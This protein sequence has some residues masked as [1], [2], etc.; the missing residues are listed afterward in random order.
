MALTSGQAFMCALLNSGTIKCWGRNNHG[1]LG[2]GTTLDS[3]VPTQVLNI[4]DARAIAAGK[5]HT[6]ALLAGG[7]LQCWGNNGGV[8]TFGNGTRGESTATPV[9]GAAFSGI[10]QLAAGVDN[11]CVVLSDASVRC[12]GYGIEGQLGTLEMRNSAVPVSP[13]F[14]GS[15]VATM[16]VGLA[17]LCAVTPNGGLECWGPTFS[18]RPT[19]FGN[20]S[21]GVKSVSIG[22]LVCLTMTDG[23][24]RCREQFTTT[25]PIEW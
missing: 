14:A 19:P 5:N 23:S 11:T 20:L 15:Q 22:T 8:G 7:A 10:T 2:N 9:A 4:S 13:V 1:Q 25:A 12:W 6:C 16:S 3:V 21:S 24:V 18:T 17:G